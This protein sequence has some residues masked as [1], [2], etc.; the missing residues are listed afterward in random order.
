MA[1]A[2]RGAVP[3]SKASAGALRFAGCVAQ[4]A[5]R[6]C[7][8]LTAGSL[9]GATGL[10]VSPDGRNVYATSYGSDTVTTFARGAAGGLRF[11]GCLAD[12]GA[13]GCIAAPGEPLRGAAGIAVSQNG[14]DVFVASGLAE[15]VSRLGRGVDGAL[16]FESC[17]SDRGAGGCAALSGPGVLA[18]ATAVALGP[19]GNDVYVAS[20][21]AGT[22]AHLVRAADGS[23]RLRDCVSGGGVEGCRKLPGN[24]LGGADALTVSRDGHWLYVASYVSN[25]LVRFRIGPGGALAFRGCI[26]DGGA[27]NCAKLSHGSL[28]GAAGVAVSGDGR[29]VYVASQVGTVLRLEPRKRRGFEFVGCI[30]QRASH[31]CPAAHRPVLSQATGIAVSPNGHDL[32]VATQKAGAIVHLRPGRRGSLAF[33]GCVA[34]GGTHHCARATPAALRGAYALTL[35]PNGRTLYA[36]AARGEA[37]SS[38]S[39]R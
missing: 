2:A 20:V 19:G 37:I 28:S 27:N 10:A 22:V 32:Y 6:G 3:G 23:L 1:V 4:G 14:G 39:R 17:L 7:S 24:S 9:V 38:F 35:A 26:A 8:R 31:G 5:A 34:P 36:T 30:A 15:S 21:D 33:A 25:A 11:Q 18:G 13:G 16:N 29:N 12:D